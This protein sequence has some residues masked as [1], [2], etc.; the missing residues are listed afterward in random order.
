[1]IPGF[2]TFSADSVTV[3]P[4]KRFT[5][6]D[7]GNG[8]TIII[9]NQNPKDWKLEKKDPVSDL[10]IAISGFKSSNPNANPQQ[11]ADFV[12]KHELDMAKAK[13]QV[14]INNP[15]G[16]GNIPGGVSG[17][18]NSQGVNEGALQGLDPGRAALVKKIANYEIPIPNSRSKEG[19]ALLSRVS[20][21]D[22]TFDNQQYALRNGIRKSFTSGPDAKNITS[23]NTAVHHLDQ[24]DKSFSDLGN[25][26]M[27]MWNTIANKFE[28]AT[29][30]PKLIRVVDDLNAV[31]GEL[32]STF[33]GTGATDQEIKAWETGFS[34]SSSPAQAKASIQEGVK[35]LQGRLDALI[36]KYQTGMGTTKDLQI[37]SPKSIHTLEKLGVDVERYKAFAK[38]GGDGVP[39]KA[40]A[41]KPGS[42]SSFW[43]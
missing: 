38:G 12:K 35:L 23:L 26:S 33:K 11:V 42:L 32:A 14:I 2:E 15:T 17:P 3:D 18:L 13:R 4:N 21:Y 37:L 28:A 9:D 24:L 22:P 43:K 16:G 20:L 19:I 34:S 36:D 41:A 7:A 8:Q 1:M 5:S 39:Q 40:N 25:R 29:G 10:Q 30:D 31:K 6:I 27:P